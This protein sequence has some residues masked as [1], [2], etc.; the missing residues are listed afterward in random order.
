MHQPSSLKYKCLA[1]LATNSLIKLDKL[2]THQG[3]QLLQLA[4]ANKT[5]SLD[6]MA[7]IARDFEWKL[8]LDFKNTAILSNFTIQKIAGKLNHQ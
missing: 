3:N 4:V 1:I 2:T 6:F 5:L 8:T 7:K